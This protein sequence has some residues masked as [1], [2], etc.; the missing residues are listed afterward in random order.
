[1][2]LDEITEVLLQSAIGNDHRLSEKRTDLG[3]AN[4]EHIAEP[5][6][7]RQGNVVALS[8][9]AIAQPGPVHKQVQP[10]L[11]ANAADGLQLI[12]GIQGAQLRR[13]GKIDQLRLNR[14]LEALVRPVGQ[15]QVLDLQGG[16]FAV[17]PGNCQNLVAGGL[18]GAGLVAVDMGGIRTDGTLMGPQRSGNHRQVGLGAPHQ[19]MDRQRIVLADGPYFRRG[20]GAVAIRAVTAGLLQIGLGQSLQDLRMAAL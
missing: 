4:I 8:R 3:T 9:Q 15:N 12:Q 6:Q 11:P 13:G 17:L 19:E 1:M 10:Q 18:D 7:I 2:L 20:S 16:D 14:M 5:G